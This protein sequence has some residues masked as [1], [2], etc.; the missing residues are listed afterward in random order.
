MAESPNTINVAASGNR[1]EIGPGTKRAAAVML[2]LG[3][4][5]A[6]TLFRLMNESEVRNIAKGAKELRNAPP[7]VITDALQKF[8]EAME[9]VGGEVIAGEEVLRN[10]AA[11]AL[12]D[13]V[14]RR[15]FDGVTPP[16][17]DEVLGPVARADPEALAMVL[18]REQPQTVALVLSALGTEKAGIVMNFLPPQMRP[19]VLRRM[20]TVESVS[21]EVLKEVGDALAGELRA[22]VAGGM[23]KVDGKSVAVELLRRVPSSQQT[24]VVEQIE[25]EDPNLAVELRQ[26]LFTFEDL[27]NLLDRDIQTLIKEVDLNQLSIALKGA[28]PAV[29]DKFFKN[30][31]TRAAQMLADDMQAAGPIRL[32]VV[33]KAQ[34]D[35]VMTA[36][37]LAQK[38]RI[39]IVRPADKMV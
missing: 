20:A 5:I 17:P 29:K 22:I 26:R 7:S 32:S 36:L 16:S 31:S 2:G 21:P 10:A 6:G 18:S 12:G 33:E 23:R 13:D 25:K 30:M 19:S 11:R 15:A 35:L 38:D 37:D 27:A 14:V 4:E 24:D 9:G 1:E 8:I 39:T 3:P 34:A 28:T